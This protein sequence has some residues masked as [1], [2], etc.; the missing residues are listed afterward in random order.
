MGRQRDPKVFWWE[1]QLGESSC[2]SKSSKVSV[3]YNNNKIWLRC[4]DMASEK[5]RI[6]NSPVYNSSVLTISNG[7][8]PRYLQEANNF[9]PPCSS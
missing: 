3:L 2:A 9:L 1:G 6:H 4:T 7:K 5:V 8:R